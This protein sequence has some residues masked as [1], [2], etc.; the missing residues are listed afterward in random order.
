MAEEVSGDFDVSIA[1]MS[2]LV[3][4]CNKYKKHAI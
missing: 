2:V 3:K 1:V 4:P